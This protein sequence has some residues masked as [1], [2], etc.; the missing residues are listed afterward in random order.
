[1]NK[2]TELLELVQ[3]NPELPVIFLTHWDVVQEDHGYW[4]G[5]IQNIE[6]IENF[7]E[8][9]D[10]TERIY[11]DKDEFLEILE[12]TYEYTEEQALE[13]LKKYSKGKHII[14]SLGI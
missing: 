7:I 14:V 3:E 6:V 10:I 4:K 13:T 8:D 5:D 9:Y 12:D 1:M 11:T 2:L